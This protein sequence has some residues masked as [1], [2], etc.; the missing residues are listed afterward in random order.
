MDDRAIV[1]ALDE[2]EDS[3]CPGCGKPFSEHGKPGAFTAVA[4]RCPEL[5]AL[6]REQVT[7]ARRDGH[8]DAKPDPERARRWISGTRAQIRA[9]ARHITAL[10][11]GDVN[12]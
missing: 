2:W 3:L 5:E 9:T 11:T 1:A 10:E 12:G 8:K 4:I 7:Q 6:D